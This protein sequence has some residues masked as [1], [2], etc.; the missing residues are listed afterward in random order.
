MPYKDGKVTIHAKLRGTGE[1]SV[2]LRV[3][4]G[5]IKH[6]RQTAKL[7]SGVEKTMSWDV[8]I[9][10]PDTPWVVVAFP[11]KKLGERKE[12]FGTAINLQL[13]E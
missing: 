4:N 3:F 11:D 10:N 2:E 12:L 1:H 13:I 6:A 7:V 9:E 5:S 8:K